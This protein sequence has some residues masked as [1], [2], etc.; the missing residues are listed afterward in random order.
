MLLIYSNFHLVSPVQ[1]FLHISTLEFF[2]ESD[3]KLGLS[4]ILIYV[5]TYIFS[6]IS[7]FALF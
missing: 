4:G 6:N 7:L 5:F 1:L 3:F 2:K